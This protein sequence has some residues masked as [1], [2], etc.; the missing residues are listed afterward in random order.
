[1]VIE[2]TAGFDKGYLG[3]AQAQM[4]LDV[5]PTVGT[6][7]ICDQT[8]R[9]SPP[10]PGTLGAFTAPHCTLVGCNEDWNASVMR[11]LGC[12]LRPEYS[13]GDPLRKTPDPI[14]RPGKWR[15][16][17]CAEGIHPLSLRVGSSINRD[18]EV[19][20]WNALEVLVQFGPLPSPADL[21]AGNLIKGSRVLSK[22][23]AIP[24][25]RHRRQ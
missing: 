21:V 1:V 16:A 18:S 23:G 19:R 2:S 12:W 5:D 9:G 24:C 15:G 11:T 7:C 10:V 6:D 14:D 8:W 25:Q 17:G 13:R 4:R 3:V 20:S 22:D